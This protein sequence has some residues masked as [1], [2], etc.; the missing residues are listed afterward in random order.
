MKTFFSGWVDIPMAKVEKKND[1]GFFT[2]AQL[3]SADVYPG[4]QAKK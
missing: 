2:A 1:A 3:L 4:S